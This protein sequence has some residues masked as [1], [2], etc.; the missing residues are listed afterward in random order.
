MVYD[1]VM[2]IVRKLF[3]ITPIAIVGIFLVLLIKNALVTYSKSVQQDISE[4]KP[5]KTVIRA[6]IA[7]KREENGEKYISFKISDSEK[8][9]F[10]VSRSLYKKS[11]IGDLG[12]LSHTEEKFHYF[13]K[14]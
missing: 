13:K 7:E 6:E 11:R 4:Y 5:H 1:I 9:E 10:K 8:R 14:L 3:F 12:R 2:D